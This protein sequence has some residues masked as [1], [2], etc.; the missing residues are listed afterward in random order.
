MYRMFHHVPAGVELGVI[1]YTNV[2][3]VSLPLTVTGTSNR[4]T[5]HGRVPLRPLTTLPEDACISCA[6]KTAIKVKSYTFTQIASRY[7]Y[8]TFL[9]GFFFHG[10][11]IDC[12]T[13]SF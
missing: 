12:L 5:L 1:S 6:L 7:T 4:D 11:V 8:C 13:C 9:W 3:A 10:I 2:S